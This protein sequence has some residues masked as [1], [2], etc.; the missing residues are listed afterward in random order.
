MRRIARC[1]GVDNDVHSVRAGLQELLERLGGRHCADAD[2]ELGLERLRG[3]LIPEKRVISVDDA[4]AVVWTEPDTAERVGQDRVATGRAE[5]GRRGG[6]TRRFTRTADDDAARLPRNLGCKFVERRRGGNQ[7]A[8][9]RLGT[10]VNFACVLEYRPRSEAMAAGRR[11]A[12]ARGT[13]D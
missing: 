7:L 9:V 13:G 3:F 2:H 5:C 11:E 1:A 6:E 10:R 4:R 8:G 12:A